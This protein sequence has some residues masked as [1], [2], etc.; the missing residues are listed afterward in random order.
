M[1]TVLH[2]LNPQEFSDRET[3]ALFNLICQFLEKAV[4]DLED[5]LLPLS[6][7]ITGNYD[8]YK[9]ADSDSD[10]DGAKAS[11]YSRSPS[12]KGNSFLDGYFGDSADDD[13]GL[14]RF[15]LIDTVDGFLATIIDSWKC[16]TPFV[17]RSILDEKLPEYL[18]LLLLFLPYVITRLFFFLLLLL[19]LIF[20]F[21]FFLVASLTVSRGSC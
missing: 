12:K 9:S 16:L 5:P 18:L 11:S 10:Y 8:G 4:E 17:T 3:D 21:V 7:W 6:D 15:P 14:D 1:L 19:L 2:V 13:G 20:M